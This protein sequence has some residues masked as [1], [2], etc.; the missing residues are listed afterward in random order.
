M[1][2]STKASSSS[3]IAGSIGGFLIFGQRLLPDA[4][5]PFARRA[6]EPAAGPLLEIAPVRDDRRI[7]GGRVALERVLRAEEVPARTHLSHRVEPERVRRSMSSGSR[8][9]ATICSRS[10]VEGEFLVGADQPAL[11]PAGRVQDEIAAAH[12]RAPQREHALIGG[13]RVDRVG[14]VGVGGAVGQLVAPRQLAADDRSLH[15]FGRAEG[16]RP[17]LHVDIGGEAAI[18]ERGAGSCQLR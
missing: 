17:G 16:R 1:R 15:V 8:N 5:W 2:R 4:R 10:T 14:G 18:D 9:S 3:R 7:E 11:H 12:D 6:G 13:L